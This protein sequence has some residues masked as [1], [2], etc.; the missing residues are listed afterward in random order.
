MT[1]Q[2][3]LAEAL[4]DECVDA[5]GYHRLLR[6]WGFRGFTVGFEAY[7]DHLVELERCYLSLAQQFPGLAPTWKK[8]TCA[9]AVRGRLNGIHIATSANDGAHGPAFDVRRPIL[10]DANGMPASSRL[11]GSDRVVGYRLPVPIEPPAARGS[12][13]GLVMYAAS[14]AVV[15][16]WDGFTHTLDVNGVN[17][18]AVAEEF[19]ANVHFH[20]LWPSDP[21]DRRAD[22][23]PMLADCVERIKSMLSCDDDGEEEVCLPRIRRD[24]DYDCFV[25]LLGRTVFAEQE[26][27]LT[28]YVSRTSAR[29]ADASGDEG[30]P[31]ELVEDVLGDEEHVRRWGNRPSCEL[32]DRELLHEWHYGL[33]DE[34][35]Q[36]L[37]A[38][39]RTSEIDAD[40]RAASV[41][42]LVATAAGRVLLA[43][44]LCTK[45]I[46]KAAHLRLVRLRA[47]EEPAQRAL[48]GD[49]L[50]LQEG[51]ERG[52]RPKTYRL[53]PTFAKTGLCLEVDLDTR[54]PTRCVDFQIH[55]LFALPPDRLIPAVEVS[56]AGRLKRTPR[57]VDLIVKHALAREMFAFNANRGVIEFVCAEPKPVAR[58]ADSV[59]APGI[60]AAAP[61]DVDRGSLTS[62]LSPSSICI[63]NAHAYAWARLTSTF[64]SLVF[65]P[66]TCT[67]EDAC[68]VIPADQMARVVK[69]LAGLAGGSHDIDD[70][71]RHGHFVVYVAAM[72][73]AATGHRPSTQLLHFLFTADAQELVAF[74]ADKGAIGS[75]ARFVPL[76][77][78][79]ID[80]LMEYRRSVT[81]LIERTRR[82]NPL[83]ATEME[84]AIGAR[85]PNVPRGKGAVGALFIVKDGR[86][87]SI[88]HKLIDDAL[89]VAAR[90]AMGIETVRIDARSLR[91]NLITFMANIG[92]SGM[93]LEMQLGHN[94]DQ[95]IAGAASNWIPLHQMAQT[96][97]LVNRYLA[98][99]GWSLVR[100]SW[101][102]EKLRP[103]PQV[104]PAFDLSNEAFEGRSFSHQEARRRVRSAILE[105]IAAEELEQDR[106]IVIDEAIVKRIRGAIDARS[107]GVPSLKSLMDDQL[108]DFLR[109]WKSDANFVLEPEQV[110]ESL[111]V[112]VADGTYGK[113]A[114]TETGAGDSAKVVLCRAISDVL[115]P[116]RLGGEA[117]LVISNAVVRKIKARLAE[118]LRSDPLA[119]QKALSELAAMAATW[120][121]RGGYLV[122]AVSVNLARFTPGPLTVNFG[123]HLAIARQFVA[124]APR[125]IT[126]HLRR[127]KVTPAQRLA[128]VVV[129]FV[130]CDAVL[131]HEELP[132]LLAAVQDGTLARFDGGLQL[133][134][135]IESTHVVYD[136]T[137]DLTSKTS[138][139]ILGY[140]RNVDS[141]AQDTS[142]EEVLREADL[143]VLRIAGRASGLTLERLMTV[144]RPFWYLRMPGATYAACAGDITPTAP[145]QA[146]MALLL[147]GAAST[148]RLAEP[149]AKD[150]RAQGDLVIARAVK[151]SRKLLRDAA[152]L[153]ESRR[154]NSRNQRKSL[155]E[156]LK[157]KLEP[158]L[159]ALSTEVPTVAL[160]ITFIE[161]LLDVGG[162]RVK[163]FRFGTLLNYQYRVLEGMYQAAW[164]KDLLEMDRAALDAL[165]AGLLK[166]ASGRKRAKVATVLR[167]FHRH[168][169]S[170]HGVGA[171]SQFPAGARVRRTARS[172]LLPWRV[173]GDAVTLASK[174]GG[175][176]SHAGSG[177]AGLLAVDA[178]YG[179]RTGEGYATRNRDRVGR[180][181]L[182]MRVQPNAA[183]SIKTFARTVPANAGGEML[184]QVIEQRAK[185][186]QGRPGSS[187][188]G[189]LFVDPTDRTRNLS[190]RDVV[191]VASWAIKAAAGDPLAIPYSTRHV[192]ASAISLHLLVPD[193]SVSP[194]ACR[195]AKALQIPA[196]DFRALRPF[197]S[198]YPFGLD[199]LGY[200]LG[201]NGVD[202]L[203]NVYSHIG[204]TAAGEYCAR[205]ALADPWPDEA[206]AALLGVHRT[207]LLRSR[208]LAAPTASAGE[209]VA[210][211]VRAY[212][213]DADW[214][215]RIPELAFNAAANADEVQVTVVPRFTLEAG[216]TLLLLR[217]DCDGDTDALVATAAESTGLSVDDVRRFY[218]AYVDVA[219]PTQ[220]LDFEPDPRAGGRRVEFGVSSA[221]ARRREL[222]SKVELI[223]AASPE[224]QRTTIDVAT[225][226][227]ERV[228]SARPL[229]IS[230]SEGELQLD[231]EWLEQLGYGHG[232]IRVHSHRVPA[233]VLDRLR[234]TGYRVIE[235]SSRPLGRHVLVHRP[236]Q[237]G[238]EAVDA[239]KCATGRDLHRVLLALT[240]A[241]R[242]QLWGAA[243]AEPV[244]SGVKIGMEYVCVR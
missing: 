182:A 236:K 228:S 241:R 92:A 225:R 35:R 218:A 171:C 100:A 141:A 149:K 142:A 213:N 230:S 229:L 237:F 14:L 74:L 2:A 172:V 222:L 84:V 146:S 94:S 163:A 207:Q 9:R 80:Q 166:S 13:L 27:R 154:A 150:R 54:W 46:E 243:L 189:W 36:I 186:T 232:E 198:D 206:M 180:G 83:L 89:A 55:E 132:L 65:E 111:R 43:A 110:L 93:L 215:G 211:A 244:D 90:A 220:F 137:V 115:T 174:V 109:S 233:A 238:I 126:D 169:R 11:G 87:E 183:R 131:N 68:M 197:A 210:A 81:W 67:D 106:F 15:R 59:P 32:E 175:A 45:T 71:T 105:A 107:K 223:A 128:A 195:M 4:A 30:A 24:S 152:G 216:D 86:L 147:G 124:E 138:A 64:T 173:V 1:E 191:H 63:R 53:P 193:P 204:W 61:V 42:D 108:G 66:Q 135:R 221:S 76:V 212:V 75:E 70:F 26:P 44:V 40:I 19:A 164:D 62:Y 143:L 165:Y 58:S 28:H 50:I 56:I 41:D 240:V 78:L 209:Q 91:R 185:Q 6:W 184:R 3:R 57:Q 117:K 104:L 155:R 25:E 33:T 16:T 112:P 99:N 21:P 82:G 48:P 20:D 18:L 120:R 114:P 199:R 97:E 51:A 187:D 168:L 179:L 7:L 202:M 72:Y 123:R 226:W 134:A 140:L 151:I 96:R 139:A 208:K 37:A 156:E 130:L 217:S 188:D 177:A 116:E 118:T 194:I 12:P 127:K 79:L 235:P 38:L 17:G 47:D 113:A 161:Y 77:R 153:V 121:K 60:D 196:A 52:A 178:S 239:R 88:G 242:S 148:V 103:L 8:M 167:L 205:N 224:F 5:A 181:R 234:S 162:L 119:Q 85:H 159:L 192:F 200:W 49:L 122:S 157:G 129:M 102:P 190:Q 133:R 231:L 176:L 73:E 158:E 95:H 22:Y 31:D 170:W 145:S 125:A 201:H 69:Q 101:V 29:A 219:N 203:H 23:P 98:V 227:A 214:G 34:Q 39:L 10:L 144:M 160:W 136:R